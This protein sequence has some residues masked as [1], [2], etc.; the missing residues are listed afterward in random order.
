ME[1]IRLLKSRSFLREVEELLSDLEYKNIGMGLEDFCYIILR[2]IRKNL[3]AQ[4]SLELP[5]KRQFVHSLC[6]IFD[7]VDIDNR[8]LIHWSD[9]TDFCVSDGN[10]NFDESQ[11]SNIAV[12]YVQ[13]RG[14]S[15]T[16]AAKHLTFLS[17]TQEVIVF[18]TE[19][20]TVRIYRFSQL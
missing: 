16:M 10:Y 13:N 9:F 12:T 14:K 20:P 18:E 2:A 19:S 5:D 11:N 15:K 3:T 1:V 7:T 8:G 6:K 17:R 4:E